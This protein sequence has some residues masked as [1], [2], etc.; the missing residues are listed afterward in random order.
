MN[1]FDIALLGLL[2]GGGS[3]AAL[4]GYR[5]IKN[6]LSPP[7]P[8][9]QNTLELTLPKGRVPKV[10]ED[11][12]YASFEG[13]KDFLTGSLDYAL[14]VGVGAAATYGGFK[15][16]QALNERHN[17]A[18]MDE[19][20][21][22]VKQ[23]YLAALQRAATK[24]ASETPHVDNF[25]NGLIDKKA[26]V[27]AEQFRGLLGSIGNGL[28]EAGDKA[29]RSEFAKILGAGGLLTAGGTALGTYYLANRLDKNKAEAQ[30]KS[31]IPT[32]V[33]LHVQ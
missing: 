32:E 24:T 25:I 1:N 3:Y 10:Q 4:R 21:E 29:L 27:I 22:R 20:Q 16:M 30:Q 11:I 28:D 2:T 23:Q 18:L 12:K 31:N 8:E 13:V 14:P 6:Q 7:E 33:K 5:D 19:E 9:N 17:N 15:G 26:E